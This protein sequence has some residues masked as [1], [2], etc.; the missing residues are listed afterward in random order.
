MPPG[1]KDNRVLALCCVDPCHIGIKFKT[2]QSLSDR[3]VDFLVLLA[4]YM[5][6]NRAYFH[7]I[8]PKSTKVA[9]FLGSPSWCDQWLMTQRE[10]IAFP[11]LLAETFSP[12]ME[13]I[14]HQ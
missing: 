3:Y 10:G 4:L 7:Y 13:P 8:N 14:R 2:I 12:N 9:E 5:D 6:A 11:R 1:S